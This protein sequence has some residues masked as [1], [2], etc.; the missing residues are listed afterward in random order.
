LVGALP[1][2]LRRSKLRGKQ[3]SSGLEGC[4]CKRCVVGKL[5][6]QDVRDDA[7]CRGF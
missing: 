6:L 2:L 5:V 1:Q 3:P 7:G 4:C